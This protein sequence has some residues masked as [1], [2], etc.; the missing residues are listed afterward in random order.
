MYP[1]TTRSNYS[2]F[3]KSR[4]QEPIQSKQVVLAST[5]RRPGAKVLS[6]LIYQYRKGYYGMAQ[7]RRYLKGKQQKKKESTLIQVFRDRVNAG[8]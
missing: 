8:K 2:M 5:K 7:C 6:C 3:N 4:R 1:S